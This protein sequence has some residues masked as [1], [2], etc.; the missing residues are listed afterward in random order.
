MD[1]RVITV[2]DL[3]YIFVRTPL[4]PMW[5]LMDVVDVVSVLILLALPILIEPRTLKLA[6]WHLSLS[7][8][9]AQESNRNSKLLNQVA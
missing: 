4:S 8:V 9:C 2:N 6:K 5:C 7:V 3:I 1:A